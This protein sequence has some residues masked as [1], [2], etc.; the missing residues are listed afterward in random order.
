[1]KIWNL[2]ENSRIYTSNVFLVLGDWNTVNDVNTLIDVGSDPEIIQNLEKMHTGLGKKK[3]DQ[4][5]LTHSH[6]DHTGILSAIIEAYHPKVYAFNTHMKGVDYLL[7]DGD[8]IVIAD[9]VFE[10]Y[11]ITSHSYDSICLYCKEDEILFAGDTSF[12]IEFENAMLE[13][14]NSYILS[15]LISK[16]VKFIYNGHGPLSDYSQKKFKLLK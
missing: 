11:H 15:R 8:E 16:P 1:M 10:V 9:R 14:E 6:S 7:N 4:V 2:S 13:A 3:V 5:I 12:P